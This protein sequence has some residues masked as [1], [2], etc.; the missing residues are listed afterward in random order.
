MTLRRVSDHRSEPLE[1]QQ[2]NGPALAQG[3]AQALGVVV[4]DGAGGAEG[5]IG[6]R[7]AMAG[8]ARPAF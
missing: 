7:V 6:L 4:K 2:K 3:P 5:V 8:Q 1:Q